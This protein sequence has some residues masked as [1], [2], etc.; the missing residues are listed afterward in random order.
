VLDCDLPCP[1]P[2]WEAGAEA[3]G[4][5]VTVTGAEVGAVLITG[6]LDTRVSVGVPLA[7]P[8]GV[9]VA[10]LCREAAGELWA[11]RAATVTAGLEAAPGSIAGTL[12]SPVGTPASALPGP[13]PTGIGPDG[14]A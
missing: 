14:A 11:V 6:A 9:T 8:A 2:L 1:R 3:A 5:F 13:P 7:V 12:S 4:D 10:E